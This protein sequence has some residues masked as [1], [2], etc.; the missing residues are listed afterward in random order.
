MKWRVLA[1]DGTARVFDLPARIGS[2]I[3]FEVEPNR[4]YRW[5]DGEKRLLCLQEID[6]GFYLE[7]IVSVRDVQGSFLQEATVTYT[8]RGKDYSFRGGVD[9]GERL[10][11]KRKHDSFQAEIFSPLAG[12][13]VRV[14]VAA[15]MKIKKG[16][17][18]V[19]IEAMK[20]ENV[21]RATGDGIVASV[22]IEPEANVNTGDLLFTLR[23]K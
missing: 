2:H 17:E 9:Y 19:V 23:R 1:E 11:V 4:I 3:Q 21:I 5:D 15:G 10:S 6:A 22:E 8:A 14:S 16:M 20:M 12:K 7:E 13:V 18:L